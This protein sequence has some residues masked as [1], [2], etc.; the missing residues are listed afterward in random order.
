MTE[1]SEEIADADDVATQYLWR[2]VRAKL[3]ARRGRFDE[4]ESMGREAIEIIET[5][6]D[7][8]SQ[9]YAWIDLAEVLRMA[10]STDRRDRGG[11]CRPPRGSTRRRTS[12]PPPVPGRSD[13]PSRSTR[14]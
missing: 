10:G 4:A 14:T 3:L 7:P 13:G 11:R 9:G 12:R 5:A 2:S 6:Q 1:E 8:D